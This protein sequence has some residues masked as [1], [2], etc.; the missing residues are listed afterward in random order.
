MCNVA[1]VGKKYLEVM[2]IHNQS[3]DC[4]HVI[5]QVDLYKSIRYLMLCVLLR[6]SCDPGSC[7]M[8]V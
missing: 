1:R 2:A 4:K 8:I 6:K 3:V 5:I 7:L